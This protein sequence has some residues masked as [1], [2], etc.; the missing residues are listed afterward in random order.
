MATRKAMTRLTS[1]T[2]T[3]AKFFLSAIL[4]SGELYCY[5]HEAIKRK[6]EKNSHQKITEK[7]VKTIFS[8]KMMALNNKPFD[9]LNR[10]LILLVNGSYGHGWCWIAKHNGT[11]PTKA[12]DIKEPPSLLY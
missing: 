10:F 5:V 2:L 1:Q 6:G 11:S 4:K 12:F 8:R 3:A 7:P 9:V